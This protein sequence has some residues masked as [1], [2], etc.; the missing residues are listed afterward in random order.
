M[1]TWIFDD[2]NGPKEMNDGWFVDPFRTGRGESTN[3][4]FLP[5]ELQPTLLALLAGQSPR[6]Y[7]N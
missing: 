4:L 5:M 3:Y 6:T 2:W 7:P 1:S